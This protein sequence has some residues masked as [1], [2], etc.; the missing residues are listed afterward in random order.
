[1]TNISCKVNDDSASVE[2][3][4]RL[5]NNTVGTWLTAGG[6]HTAFLG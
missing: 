4:L 1:M 5:Q 2:S 6:Y 3:W